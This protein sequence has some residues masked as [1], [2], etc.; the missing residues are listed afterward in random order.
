M[1]HYSSIENRAETAFAFVAPQTWAV[2]FGAIL[3]GSALALAIHFQYFL[4]PSFQFAADE[5][6]GLWTWSNLHQTEN[7]LKSE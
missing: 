6:D 4:A 1:K 7:I 5:A 2:A 3:H